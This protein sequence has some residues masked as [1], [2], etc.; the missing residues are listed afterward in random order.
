[1][2]VTPIDP[3]A[4]VRLGLPL[5]PW[6]PAPF[7]RGP[8]PFNFK[9]AEKKALGQK[10]LGEALF[11]HPFMNLSLSASATLLAAIGTAKLDGVGRI[12]AWA[13]LIGAGS[14]TLLNAVRYF[15]SPS[16]A[17]PGGTP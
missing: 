8:S 2:E 11:D 7:K 5:K 17:Y 15:G 14:Q 4:K 3:G 10:R 6:R 13:V 1:M 12:L 9:A 16:P